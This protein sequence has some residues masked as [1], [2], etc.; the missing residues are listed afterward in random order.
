LLPKVATEGSQTRMKVG[1]A[2]HK[3]K[4]LGD[5]H[6]RGL[7]NELKYK[8]TSYYEIKGVTKPGS[9]LAYLINTT[10]SDLWGGLNDVR[11]YEA[12]MGICA[13]KQFVSF[14]K[15]ADIL[16]LSVPQIMCKL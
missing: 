16:V 5:S 15:H 1:K 10:S 13:L 6:A 12:N 11:R 2:K 9:T 14:H 8:L 7:A 4:I 3:I